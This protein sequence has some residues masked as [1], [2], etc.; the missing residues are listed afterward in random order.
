MFKDILPAKVLDSL[1]FLKLDNLN[2]I[3]IR[4]SKPII[5]DYG[6][7]YYLG[8]NG[9]AKNADEA[10]NLNEKEINNIVYKA[11]ECT[12]YAYNEQIKNGFI[13]LKNGVRL[14]LC[15]EVV[16]ENKQIKTIKN[17]S[18]LNIRIPHT[19]KGCSLTALPYLQEKGILSTLIIGPAYSGKTTFLRDLTY[20]ISNRH[21][22]Q[23]ILL[24]DERNELAATN[25]G[26]ATMEI[27]DFVDI[28]TGASKEFA[29]LN[30]IRVMSPNVIVLD[31]I[32]S[33]QD[34]FAVRNAVGA[35]VKIIATTHSQDLN[36]LHNKIIFT[37]FL[38]EQVFERFVVLSDRKGKG[39]LEGVWDKNEICLYCGD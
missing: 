31:E 22:E 30:G 32:V 6:G 9:L 35:G 7:R 4:N 8:E 17:F 23:N 38:K 3:R 16:Y 13:T 12:I 29:I 28:Y 39:T 11:C 37:D 1:D 34:I 21:I 26:K 19:I 10:I 24:V 27:G 36:D 14:G 5:V 33:M 15:G 20:Q 18:S 2:E 25:L